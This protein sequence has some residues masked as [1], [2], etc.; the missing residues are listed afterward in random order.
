MSAFDGSPLLLYGR[1]DGG[2]PQVWAQLCLQGL[3]C[4]AQDEATAA[5]RVFDPIFKYLD[6]GDQWRT[7]LELQA[8]SQGRGGALALLVL[9][10]LQE[11]LDASGKIMGVTHLGGFPADKYIA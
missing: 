8:P 10:D 1:S 11:T 9:Q 6:N 7:E 4:I 5:P 2:H 3:A